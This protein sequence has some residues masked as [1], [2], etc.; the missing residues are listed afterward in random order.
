MAASEIVI[1]TRVRDDVLIA[2]LCGDVDQIS[3]PV[4]AAFVRER[5]N[6]HEDFV[7]DLRGIGFLGAAGL[8]VLLRMATA[9]AEQGV[10]WAVVA[11]GPVV[12]RAIARTGLSSVL[13]T[14]PTLRLALSALMDPGHS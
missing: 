12:N 11:R 2:Y 6:A 3:A 10:A 9:S 1:T 5:I 8:A 7:L 14:H 13:P 4:V